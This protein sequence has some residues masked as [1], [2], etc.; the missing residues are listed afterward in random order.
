LRWVALQRPIQ[1]A[2]LRF[3]GE[4]IDRSSLPTL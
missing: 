3:S 1:A 2:T 4:L